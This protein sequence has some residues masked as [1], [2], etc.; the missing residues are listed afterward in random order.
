V[1]TRGEAAAAVRE[2]VVAGRLSLTISTAASLGVADALASG[3][4]RADDLAAE[5]SCHSRTLYRLLRTLAAAGILREG[6]DETFE[7]TEL[8]EVLR[9]DVEGS[10]RDQAVL[11]GRPDMLAA[12]GN[13]EHSIRTGDNAFSALHGEDVWS[14]RRARPHESTIF[15]RA[16]AS[17]SAPVGPAMAAAFDFGGVA[18][19]ADIG[20]GNGTLMAAILA[21]HPHLH[22]IVFDQPAVVTQAAPVLAAA[23]LADRCEVTGGD[24]FQE[25]PAADVY[26]MKSILH[27]W[28]DADAIR[29][30]RTIRRAAGPHSRLLLVEQVLGPPNEDL[31]G[32]L[33]DLHM[34]VMPGGEERTR[35]EWAALLQAG[36]FRLVGIRP[37]VEHFQLI[38]AA[39]ASVS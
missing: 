23:G 24:F 34:L 21:R 3:P 36:G 1:T 8:G 7:L 5:L 17:I 22:G 18:R 31:G 33:S 10:V 25:V 13:L 15:N 19:V 38:E 12:W 29:I 30:L 14:W 16:M 35:D 27:D 2:M 32:K 6:P 39:P 37:V 11:Y 4:R 9:A 28:I 20:G 26:I